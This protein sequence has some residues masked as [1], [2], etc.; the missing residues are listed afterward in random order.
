MSFLFILL[1]LEI[2]TRLWQRG[3]SLITKVANHLLSQPNP[4]PQGTEADGLGVCSRGHGFSIES[5]VTEAAISY[6]G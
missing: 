6:R 3:V 1:K 4:T 5:K 2:L